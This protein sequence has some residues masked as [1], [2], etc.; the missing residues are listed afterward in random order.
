MWR[1]KIKGVSQFQTQVETS[2]LYLLLLF[3]SLWDGSPLWEESISFH[4]VFHLLFKT[5]AA[6][7][8]QVSFWE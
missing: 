4:Q 1:N 7:A 6:E 2:D 8:A 5:Q 3:F